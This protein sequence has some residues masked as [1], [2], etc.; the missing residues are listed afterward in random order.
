VLHESPRG[1]C[2][3]TSP[4]VKSFET[5]ENHGHLLGHVAALLMVAVVLAVLRP[6]R[7]RA[8]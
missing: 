7:Q 8:R 3:R 4:L 6:R 5:P 1:R 2:R